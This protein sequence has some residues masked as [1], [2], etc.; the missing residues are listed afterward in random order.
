MKAETATVT[1]LEWDDGHHALAE[2]DSAGAEPHAAAMTTATRGTRFGL[3]PHQ[4]APAAG[5]AA[6]LLQPLAQ[7]T[8]HHATLH[9]AHLL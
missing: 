4:S 7:R 5:R 6:D 8:F 3:G 1:S 2:T 9:E